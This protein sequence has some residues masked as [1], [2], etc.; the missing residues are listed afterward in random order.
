M[1]RGRAEGVV[2][3]VVRRDDAMER[4]EDDDDRDE[5]PGGDGE[6]A[7]AREERVQG[8]HA[9]G[10]VAA[11]HVARLAGD[12]ARVEILPPFED[13]ARESAPTLDRVALTIAAAFR[14]VDVDG[15]LARLDA[16][17]A[18]VAAEGIGTSAR[19]QAEVLARV[20][21]R[22]HAFAGDRER[23]Y[24][25][26]NSMLDVVLERRRGLP[27]LLS[28][29]YVEVARRVGMR[30]R[31]IA[32]HGHFVVGHFAATPPV[33]I[34]PFDGGALLDAR[35]LPSDLAPQPVHETALR[36]LTNLVGA[37]E[38]AGDHGRALRAAGMRL[39]LPLDDALA[40][41]LADEAKRLAA[42]FN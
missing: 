32:L 14:E 30:V 28:V 41:G 2:A 39:A 35:G 27:I 40:A 25:P 20:L 6:R 31:G 33:V 29:V 15:A 5:D 12:N 11:A 9:S 19:E 36:M 18:E 10:R 22:R 17:A 16:L 8:D 23:Y 3:V 42:R 38:R 4:R 21:G 34:D 37:Y 13:V 1:R 26:D 24:A 7:V